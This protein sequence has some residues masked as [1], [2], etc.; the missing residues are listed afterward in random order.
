ME[1]KAIL[2][3]TLDNLRNEATI[4]TARATNTCHWGGT[5]KKAIIVPLI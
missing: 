1:V 2:N 4:S 3:S 5:H